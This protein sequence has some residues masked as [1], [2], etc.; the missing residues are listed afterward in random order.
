MDD[1]EPLRSCEIFDPKVGTWTAAAP[2]PAAVVRAAVPCSTAA[3][4]SSS[5]GQAPVPANH[6]MERYDA[7]ADRWDFAPPCPSGLER[8]AQHQSASKNLFV[9]KGLTCS[10]FRAD[11]EAPTVLRRVDK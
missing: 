1:C 5:E 10:C 7:A 9:F 4:M 3:R 8:V 11:R 6:T 2:W